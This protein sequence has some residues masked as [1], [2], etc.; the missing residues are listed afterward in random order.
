[1][2]DY[3]KYYD[4][5]GELGTNE[6]EKVRFEQTL[7]HLLND[8]KLLDVGCGEGYWLKFLDEKTL[9]TLIGIDI[10][11]V[12]LNIAHRN[13][14]NSKKKE[15]TL[16]VSDI[17]RLPYNSNS[18]EQV[19]A[20][21]V[22]EHIGDW[23]I[24]LEELIRVASMRVII[25]VPYNEKLKYETCKKCGAEA[26]LYGHLHSFTEKDFE[27]IK[28]AVKSKFVKLPPAFGLDYYIKRA[29]RW[30]SR[31]SKSIIIPQSGNSHFLHTICPH[32][33]NKVIYTKYVERIYY[34]LN[35]IIL[36]QPEYL[37]VEIN[38]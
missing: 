36:N 25:T 16:R 14:I 35:K 22:L 28:N 3:K 34:R 17:Q 12:R 21:E 1:M 29:V 37:L 31:K 11:P 27:N 15:I 23:K 24:G 30:I 2:I 32:C 8:G 5:I 9:L 10:S 6:G 4:S 20:L 7:P 33:Y 13:L 19:T 18:I 38:K 26:F